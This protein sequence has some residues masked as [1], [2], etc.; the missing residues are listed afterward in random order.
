MKIKILLAAVAMTMS[1]NASS[2][3]LSPIY[4]DGL[5]ETV[6]SI[7]QQINPIHRIWVLPGRH[8]AITCQILHSQYLTL[9]LIL[10]CIAQPLARLFLLIYCGMSVWQTA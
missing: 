10:L 1:A 8:S 6:F 3:I 7:W 2:A 9:S 4:S 5:S